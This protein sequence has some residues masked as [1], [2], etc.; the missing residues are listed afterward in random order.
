MRFPTSNVTVLHP[1][2]GIQ[3][4]TEAQWLDWTTCSAG[5]PECWDAHAKEDASA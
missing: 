2:N 4:I 1:I 5:H 3:V